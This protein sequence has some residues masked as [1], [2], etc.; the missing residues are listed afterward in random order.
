MAIAGA[1]RWNRYRA[2]RLTGRFFLHLVLIILGLSMV[3]PLIWMVFSSF[4]PSLEVISTEFHLLPQT[5]T[6]RNY[7]RVFDEVTM[8]RGYLNSLIMSGVVRAAI[9]S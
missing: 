5:W 9:L 6:L 4:K 8:G 3:F 7:V 2:S 1:R